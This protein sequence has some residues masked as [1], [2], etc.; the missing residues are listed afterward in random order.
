MLQTA[1]LVWSKAQCQWKVQQLQ[2]AAHSANR[3]LEKIRADI[4]L[5]ARYVCIHSFLTFRVQYSPCE[6]LSLSRR[7][8]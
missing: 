4:L 2:L 5:L 3:Q 8:Y 6:G 1:M 7:Y